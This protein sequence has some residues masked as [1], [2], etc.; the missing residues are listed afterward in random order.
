MP[1]WPLL[2]ARD[3]VAEEAVLGATAA[4]QTADGA[5]R[6]FSNGGSATAR[7][8]LMRREHSPNELLE[9]KFA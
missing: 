3:V 5:S 9:L 6:E 1:C 4:R 8:W 2:I 7:E